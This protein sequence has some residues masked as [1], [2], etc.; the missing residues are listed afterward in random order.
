MISLVLLR[1]FSVISVITGYVTL[2]QEHTDM[3]IYWRHIDSNTVL[4]IPPTLILTILIKLF[5]SDSRNYRKTD[6]HVCTSYLP[7]PIIQPFYGYIYYLT[8]VFI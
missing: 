3:Y 1:N 8:V 7:M 6:F 4:L 2:L 5:L